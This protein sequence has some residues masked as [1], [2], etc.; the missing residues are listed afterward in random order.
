MFTG[1]VEEVGQ[2]LAI[3]VGDGSARLH[4]GARTVVEDTRVGDS[5]AV[6]GCCLTAT[7][8]PGDGFTADL[9]LETL[10]ATALG[11]LGVGDLVNLERAMRAD[12]RLGG[13]LVQG[14]VDGVGRILGRDELPGTVVL[15][16]QAPPEVARYLVAKGSVTVSGTS[17]TVVDVD[18]DGVFTLGLIPHTLA[19]TN[20]GVREVGDEVN[21][22]VDVVAK[23]VERLLAAGTVSPY[24]APQEGT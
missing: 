22:E 17:L 7:S 24:A 23:Y 15:S 5:I 10:R 8:F 20:L 3:E 12:A 16:I 4:V 1:I 2:V 11:R 18:G 13:H 9:M 14:H 19:A 21:L 6:D